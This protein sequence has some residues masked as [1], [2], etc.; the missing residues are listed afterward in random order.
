MLDNPLSLTHSFNEQYYLNHQS[1]SH[2]TAT[3][4]PLP[5]HL[6]CAAAA[7]DTS[8]TMDRSVSL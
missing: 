7:I 5:P 2:S 3:S 4:P 6:T 8:S 1:P